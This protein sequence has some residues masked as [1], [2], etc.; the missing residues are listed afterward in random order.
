MRWAHSTTRRSPRAGQPARLG[1][2]PAGPHD[3]RTVSRRLVGVPATT[4]S[5]PSM[6]P[7]TTSCPTV[8]PTIQ[9]ATR[10]FSAEA[11]PRLPNANGSPAADR[12][13]RHRAADRL[14]LEHNLIDQFQFW[15]FPVRV[16]KGRRLFDSLDGPLQPL[17]LTRYSRTGQ[18]RGDSQLRSAPARH[19][20]PDFFRGLSGT[21]VA[22]FR[23]R[24]A[25]GAQCARHSGSRR[26]SMGPAD[27]ALPTVQPALVSRERR[28]ARPGAR[29]EFAVIT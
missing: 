28:L 19:R 6:P 26:E 9:A 11:R 14:L 8:C 3:V 4:T 7:A 5:T 23:P 17:A 29:W 27:N 18:R 2:L 12:Q 10:R 15:I 21:P 20:L 16:G 13:V 25:S 24:D 22:T 1:R